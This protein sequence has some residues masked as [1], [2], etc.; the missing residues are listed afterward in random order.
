[1]VSFAP[2][3]TVY[4]KGVNLTNGSY[5]VWIQDD[6]VGNAD[7]LAGGEDPSGSQESVTVSG[8][9]L[10]VTSIWAIDAE[11]EKTFTNRDLVLDNQ[12]VGT[13]GTYHTA[14]DYL[15]SIGLAGFVAPVPELPTSMLIGIGLLA[16][17]AFLVLRRRRQSRTTK[18][19][20]S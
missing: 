20:A 4:V 1:M 3:Q 15:D 12:G 14:N 16:L 6:A 19:I 5:K 10:A 7:V 17:G 13:V 2:G 11:A 9:T 8:G 18:P